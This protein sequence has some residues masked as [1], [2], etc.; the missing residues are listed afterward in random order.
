MKVIDDISYSP[1]TGAQYLDIDIRPT[2]SGTYDNVDATSSTD[3]TLVIDPTSDFAAYPTADYATYKFTI[4]IDLDDS[5]YS[6]RIY[7]VETRVG[8]TGA[9]F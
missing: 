9:C 3:Y 8:G 6:L 7:R 5:P 2:N 1:P 4:T